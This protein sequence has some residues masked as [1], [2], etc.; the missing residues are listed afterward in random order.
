MLFARTAELCIICLKEPPFPDGS[1]FSKE[2]VIPNSL[3]GILTC[4]FLCKS[5]NDRFGNGF[6]A[7]AKTD[8]SI[9]L[10]ISNLHQE[11]PVLYNAIESG[12][13]YNIST[14]AGNLPGKFSEGTIRGRTRKMPD[15][16]LMVPEEQTDRKLREMLKKDGLDTAKIEGALKRFEQA[17]PEQEIE[18]VP[19]MIVIKRLATAASQNLGGGVLLD[20]LVCLKIVYEFAALLFGPPVFVNNPALNEIRRALRERDKGSS[21]FRVDI[22]NASTYRTFHGIAFE[23]NGANATFQVRLFGRLAYRV[24]LPK[25]SFDHR[26][27]AYTHHLTTGEETLN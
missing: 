9:R 24:H 21:A 8:P 6:E 23:G 13:L 10:A 2:H 5:C 15:N 20:P 17:A 22:L 4:E 11:L 14:N 18:I 27:I 3:G 16:S 26:P 1:G 12:Q 19:G 25:L 7:R